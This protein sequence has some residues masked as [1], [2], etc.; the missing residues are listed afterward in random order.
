VGG[1]A[2]QQILVARR[3]LHRSFDRVDRLLVAP[4]LLQ[5]CVQ[6]PP[7]IGIIREIGNHGAQLGLGAV[8]IA[9]SD[10]RG[11]Q[12]QPNGRRLRVQG[13]GAPKRFDRLVDIPGGAVSV[14]EVVPALEVVRLPRHRLLV[15]AD[16]EVEVL[17]HL[18]EKRAKLEQLAS[19]VRL[20]HLV[21][22][23]VERLGLSIQLHQRIGEIVGDHRVARPRSARDAQMLDRL[24]QIAGPRVQHPQH[25]VERRNVPALGQSLF[26]DGA[27]LA[28]S[29]CGGRSQGAADGVRCKIVHRRPGRHEALLAAQLEFGQAKRCCSEKSRGGGPKIRRPR[30]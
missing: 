16:G 27:R 28:Q 6:L 20:D 1:K 12:I 7:G 30:K 8:P 10:Q 21:I 19:P 13:N 5:Q 25:G 9:C 4:A 17:G 15:T 29:A 24:I 18:R 26:A 23:D 2:E 22:Q 11:R 14:A 3:A